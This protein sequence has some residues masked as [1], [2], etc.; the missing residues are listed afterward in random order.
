MFLNVP[1]DEKRRKKW[2]QAVLRDNPKT[3]SNF[4]VVKITLIFHPKPGSTLGSN[5]S[6]VLASDSGSVHGSNPNFVFI[7]DL[8]STLDLDSASALV[9]VIVH[10]N[11]S[12]ANSAGRACPPE[13]SSGA[14]KFSFIYLYRNIIVNPHSEINSRRL[15]EGTANA[16]CNAFESY[17]LPLRAEGRLL[18]LG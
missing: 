2:F 4:F 13:R 8:G 11:I 15:L 18:R 10:W 3:K 9:P 5:L 6:S 17:P 14:G 1:Q 12:P 7:S 16:G